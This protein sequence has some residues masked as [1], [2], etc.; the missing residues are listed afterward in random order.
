MSKNKPPAETTRGR[1]PE[2]V[3]PQERV[4]YGLSLRE[5]TPLESHAEWSPGPERP[6]PVQL[7]EEQ[8]RDRLSW[9]VPVRRARMSV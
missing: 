8:N 1:S 4:E 9:L 2:S 3:T 6:D 7:I 5:S